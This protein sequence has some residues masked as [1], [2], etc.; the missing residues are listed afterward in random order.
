LAC[1]LG[2]ACLALTGCQSGV[3]PLH[4]WAIARDGVIAP[5]PTLDELGDTRGR[6]ARWFRPEKLPWKSRATTGPQ[7]VLA[8]SDP[9]TEAEF[10]AALD[11]FRQG[12]LAAAERA[13]TRLDKR[14]PKGGTYTRDVALQLDGDKDQKPQKEVETGGGRFVSNG[15]NRVWT[16]WGERIL[17][18]LAE[19]KYQRGNYQGAADT[20]DRL[21][22][23]Y[24]GTQYLD[25]SVERLFSIAQHWLDLENSTLAAEKKPQT[26]WNDRV[27]GKVP[28]VDAG[29][30][31]LRVLEHVRH[32]DVRGPLADDA[33]MRI[34]DFHARHEDYESAAHYY[35]ELLVLSPKSPLA[36]EARMESIECKVKAYLG[37]DYDA[38]GLES[39]RNQIRQTM[40]VYPERRASTDNELYSSLA[41]ID[42]QQAAIAY[43]QGEFYQRTGKVT[44]AELYY[45]EVVAR[46]PKSKWAKEA[47]THLAQLKTLPK[48]Q[49]LPSKILTPPGSPDPSSGGST[50]GQ[51]AT[52]PGSFSPSLGAPNGGY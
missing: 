4:R 33:T 45:G 49:T 17:Y 32:H 13:F 18:Y 44:A 43:R 34:A 40:R 8:R 31:A 21:L 1:A 11:L 15:Q 48:Q 3:G 2:L 52:M 38:S 30:H 14:Q 16:P 7:P 19:T 5:P 36:H 39:A 25:R 27:T 22:S 20:Y 28:L 46:W 37:P 10:Q 35:D 42:D 6:L 9:K 41:L 47:K 26:A 29:G 23:E 50:P 12:D 24:R 51:M